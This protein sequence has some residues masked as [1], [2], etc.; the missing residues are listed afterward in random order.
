MTR[1]QS[2]AAVRVDNAQVA[3][4]GAKPPEFDLSLAEAAAWVGSG[5]EGIGETAEARH[6][7]QRAVELDPADEEET[8]AAERLDAL[9]EG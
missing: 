8:D 4:E 2:R 6:C 7:Y 1:G 9:R 5:P 3:D